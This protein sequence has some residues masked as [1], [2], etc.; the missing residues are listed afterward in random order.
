[1]TDLRLSRPKFDLGLLTNR[2]DQMLDFWTEE[3]GLPVE[4]TLEPVPGVIQ[5]KLTLHGAVLKL[6][7]V[8]RPLPSRG[9]LGGIR[10]LLLAYS[11]VDASQHLRDPDGNQLCF[12]PPGTSGVD[13]YGIHLAVSDEAAFHRFYVHVLG[14]RSVGERAYDFAGATISFAWSPDAMRHKNQAAASFSYLTFQI[15]DVFEAHELLCGRGAEEDRAP[16]KS[17][18]STASTISF[19][20]DPDGNRIEISQRPDLVAAALAQ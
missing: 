2:G 9:S 13:T 6:N 3:I 5:H 18:T 1:V 4:R 16:S 15:M 17:H 12:V 20:L 8:E 19:I 14:L 11:K 7:C 10:M